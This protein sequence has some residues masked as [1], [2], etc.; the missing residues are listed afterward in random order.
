MCTEMNFFRI[1]LD[2]VKNE[3]QSEGVQEIF[4]SNSKVKIRSIPT[5]KGLEIAKQT[6]GLL[7]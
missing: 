2:E 5:K 1:N 6:I 7:P 4:T 3:V